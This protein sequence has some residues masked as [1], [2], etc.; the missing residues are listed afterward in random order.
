MFVASTSRCSCFE[1]SRFDFGIEAVTFE[2]ED[3]LFPSFTDRT[4]SKGQSIESKQSADFT[5]ASRDSSV[6]GRGKTRCFHYCQS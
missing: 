1:S 2:I 3:W 5:T 4:A 6:S